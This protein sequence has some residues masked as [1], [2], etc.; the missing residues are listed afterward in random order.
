MNDELK[1]ILGELA[2]VINRNSLENGSNTPDFVLAKFIAGCL[3][4]WDQS[5]LERDTFYGI[6]PR[7]GISAYAKNAD[8]PMAKENAA[9]SAQNEKLKEAWNQVRMMVLCSVDISCAENDHGPQAALDAV[10]AMDAALSAPEPGADKP[11]E[12]Q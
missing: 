4:A 12:N 1:R 9:L 7:P 6:A 8:D 3:L 11:Q 10:K 5:T 2:A